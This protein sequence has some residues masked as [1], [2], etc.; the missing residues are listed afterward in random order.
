VFWWDGFGADRLVGQLR[1]WLPWTDTSY[2]TSIGQ[3]E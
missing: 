3:S 1:I 2:F